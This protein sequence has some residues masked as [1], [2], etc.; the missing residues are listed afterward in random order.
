MAAAETDPAKKGAC[1]KGACF[2]AAEE[3]IHDR[4]VAL[5]G[6]I[7]RDDLLA[8]QHARLRICAHLNRSGNNLQYAISKI[9]NSPSYDLSGTVDSIKFARLRSYI[10]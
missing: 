3:A 7:S 1:F 9:T 5:G 2:K 10:P 6:Q 8:I 4:V